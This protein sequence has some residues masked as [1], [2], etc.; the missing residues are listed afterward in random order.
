MKSFLALILLFSGLA[1][2]AQVTTFTIDNSVGETPL[3]KVLDT[4]YQRDQSTR[5]AYLD[6]RKRNERPALIDSLEQI[7]RRAD[8][9]N[10]AKVNEIIGEHGWLG[11][12]KV[13]MNASQGLF[14]VIQHA[15]LQTQERYLPMIRQAEKNGETLS[16]NL[17]ILEDRV[18]MRNG[19]KQIYGSQGFTDPL[20]GKKYIY[21][22]TDPDNLDKR[23][24]SMG[25][26]PMAE[27]VKGWDLEAYKKDLP[28]IE[29]IV[30]TQNIK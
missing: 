27:Y 13:G 24:K 14:L 3:A 23:R 30:K 7:M 28:H 2:S 19:R 4:I 1:A 20:T 18:A 16:S 8:K 22:L 5:N 9:E 26:P 12:Q 25:M 6:A 15:D 17:A 21:P 10:L 11:P 29:Q